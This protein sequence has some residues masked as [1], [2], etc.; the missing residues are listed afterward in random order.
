MAAIVAILGGI[1]GTIAALSALLFFNT[2][3]AGALAIYSASAI[4]VGLSVC[5][6]MALNLGTET[7]ALAT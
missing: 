1:T 7:K 2:G 3:V 5:I 6:A 4:G